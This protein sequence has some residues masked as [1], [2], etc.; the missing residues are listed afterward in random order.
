MRLAVLGTIFAFI[1]TSAV[2]VY[3]NPLKS[4]LPPMGSVAAVLDLTFSNLSRLDRTGRRHYLAISNSGE[5]T[6][7][8]LA[9]NISDLANNIS[10][11][12]NDKSIET[13][14]IVSSD[15]KT[16]DVVNV[17][18]AFKRAKNADFRIVGME[19][20]RQ[21]FSK[22]AR[23]TTFESYAT[24][25]A[26][27]KSHD[28]DVLVS[29]TNQP[30]SQ[31]SVFLDR[32][33]MSQQGLVDSVV[34]KSKKA[35]TRAGNM[36]K[37]DSNVSPVAYLQVGSD[38]PWKCVAGAIYNIQIS[39]IEWFTLTTPV[40]SAAIDSRQ[41]QTSTPVNANFPID[42]IQPHREMLL[43]FLQENPNLRMATTAD[44]KAWDK[45]KK[46]IWKQYSNRHPYYVSADLNS[47][48]RLDFAVVLI[49]G[50]EKINPQDG[51][52]F[53]CSLAIFNQGRDGLY[54]LAHLERKIGAPSGS[55]LF[56]TRSTNSLSVGLWESGATP[57]H[58]IRGGNY[59]WGD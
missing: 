35:I 19:H 38:T 25:T 9:T 52:F 39:G 46:W 34:R 45:D 36:D 49:D 53:N 50:N 13:V 33:N 12:I 32:V 10:K 54:K 23:S 8:G 40:D 44:Y 55:V 26:Y 24:P 15:V 17:V 47:D 43:S 30:A 3:A 48:G 56:Y 28:F 20:F 11:N 42:V 59:R 5:I 31:C 21:V 51:T 58:P 37:S 14:V 16:R 29:H 4:H 2:P 41:I 18:D 22:K 6:Y 57:I 7:N 1:V 27:R